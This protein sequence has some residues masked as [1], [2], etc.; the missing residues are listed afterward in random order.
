MRD[1]REVG[2]VGVEE[3]GEILGC[4]GGGRGEGGGERNKGGSEGGSGWRWEKVVWGM[5]RT[6][7]SSSCRR[8]SEE[9]KEGKSAFSLD[10]HLVST[11]LSNASFSTRLT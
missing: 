7:D 5:R 9:K 6:V 11:N 2:S 4:E 1:S 3:V 10:V 8:S